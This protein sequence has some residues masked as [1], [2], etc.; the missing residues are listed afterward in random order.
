ML[1][2]F[3]TSRNKFSG[4]LPSCINKLLNL[5]ELRMQGNNFSS[6]I[7]TNIGDLV[8]LTELDLQENRFS[9]IIP[10]ELGELPHLTYLNP[11]NNMLSGVIPEE[12]AKLKIIV[13]D[14]GA[15]GEE[16]VLASLKAENVIG[17]GGSGVVYKVVLKSGQEVAAKKLWEANLEEPE[18]V[19]R[20]EI[21][22]MGNIMHLNIV[23]LLF[24]CISEDYRILVY[25]YM[26]NG[27]LR[28]VL[29]GEGGGVLL[30]WPKRFAIAVGMA[31]GLAYLHHGCVPAIMHRDLKSNNIL[32]DEEFRPKLADFEYGY[33]M[34]V[35]EKTDVYSFGI[36]LL[37]LLTGKR[38]N[39]STFGEN[40][41]IVAWV[42][43]IT[44]PSKTR[45]GNRDA[46]IASLNKMLD[47][48]MNADTIE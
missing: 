12:L 1:G 17:S 4:V 28:D 35:T 43:D 42:K 44:V 9:G 27:S 39:D 20:S 21:E 37:E 25:E 19:F 38:P 8:Q 14:K 46:N 41:N 45:G 33:T 34:K 29:H 18:Q 22:T 2:R 13:F 26:K 6:E 5:T 32:L 23:K 7:P 40:T 16:D 30:D 24:S 48:Q 36:V 15:I 10:S 31:Q 11:S 3:D 47:P